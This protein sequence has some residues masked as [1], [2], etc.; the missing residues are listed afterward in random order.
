MH[1]R[2]NGPKRIRWATDI[3]T[4]FS[5]AVVLVPI[6]QAA[7]EH[8][9]RL[10]QHTQKGETKEVGDVPGHVMGVAQ[11]AGLVF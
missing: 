3:L 2:V 5:V 1:I 6:T 9:G 7:E 8:A 4:L 10:V 11:T